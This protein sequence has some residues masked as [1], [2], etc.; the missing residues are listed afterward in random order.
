MA[1]QMAQDEVRVPAP[2]TIA[3][4]SARRLTLLSD[5]GRFDWRSSWKR[6]G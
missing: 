3:A 1:T 6:V 2:T 5:S 4:S